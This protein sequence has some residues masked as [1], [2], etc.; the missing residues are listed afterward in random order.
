[1]F[2]TL[3]LALLAFVASFGLLLTTVACIG[4]D[5][6]KPDEKKKEDKQTNLVGKPAPEIAG[7]FAL[8]GKPVDLADLKGKVVLLD[9]WAVWCPPCVASFPH[10]RDWHKD[11]HDQ[12]LE[13]VGLTGYYGIGGI[14]KETGALQRGDKPTIAQEN[15]MLRDFATYHK[16]EHRIQAMA[17]EES[18]KV[19]KDYQVMAIPT[20]V[21]IDRKGVVRMIK[22][23]ADE[24]TAKAVEAEFKK[25]LEEK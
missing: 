22:V 4:A 8:N 11:Y 15:A 12:G 2:P 20:V 3:R 16:L 6:K 7:D 5:E 13:I 9:F 17:K 24:E 10:L 1:M 18:Q 21:L 23:G 25:L 14:D 19:S